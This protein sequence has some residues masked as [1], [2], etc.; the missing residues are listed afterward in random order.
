MS[1]ALTPLQP[2]E[3]TPT[4][5][6]AQKPISS[7]TYQDDLARAMDATDAT[8]VQK[9]LE[10][11]RER[12]S[13]MKDEVVRK[14]QKGWYTLGSIFLGIIALGAIAYGI[15]HY[16][17]LTV[18]VRQSFSVGVFPQTKPFFADS[19]DIRKIIDDLSSDQTLEEGKPTLVNLVPNETTKTLLSKQELFSFF[20]TK[21]TEPF[22]A[23]FGV[24]RLG[25]I[26]TGTKIVPFIIGS[27]TDSEITSKELLIAEPELLRMFYK[28]LNIPISQYGEDIG[29]T[30]DQQYMYNLPTRSLSKADDIGTD[31]LV[32][33][34]GYA[35][36]KL[37]VFSTDYTVLK[38]VYDSI[39]SQQ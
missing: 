19:T 38:S 35:T 34:Y 23:A 11:A 10:E 17:Q 12:E 3:P 13:N 15:Y 18:P 16:R 2:I 29:K 4:P 5:P 39:L 21:G 26:N 7:H 9:M 20:E 22:L 28:P 6:E 8:V 30:F 25:V 14:R 37:V 33:F 24:F 31:H 27:V 32:F 36:E 1:D